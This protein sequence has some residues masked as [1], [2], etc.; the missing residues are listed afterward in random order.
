VGYEQVGGDDPWDDGIV[1]LGRGLLGTGSDVNLSDTPVKVFAG[2]Q[3]ADDPNQAYL[4]HIVSVAAGW[5]HC[6]ALEKDDPYDPNI[7]NPAYTG[8]VF[9]WGN[10]G[11][12]WGGGDPCNLPEEVSAGGDTKGRDRG[13]NGVAAAEC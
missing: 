4:N 8:R 12:G 1:L 9:T 10:N 13:Q 2:A 5:D 3:H 6:V 11:P 7:Y